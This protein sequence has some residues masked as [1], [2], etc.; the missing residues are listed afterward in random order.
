[1]H[2]KGEKEFASNYRPISL[3]S[4]V[5]KVMKSI[6]KDDIVAFTVNNKLLANLQH[7]FVSGKSCQTNVLLM[8]NF[9]TELIE[10]GTDADLVYL[11]CAKAFDSVPQNRLICKLYNYGISGNL[12]LW[13]RN[14]LSHRRQQAWVK[15]TLSNWENVTGCVPQGSVFGPVL[16][17]I[18]IIDLPIDILVLLFL[19]AD[20]TKLMQNLIST[21]SH[22]E[23]QDDINRLFEMG[24]KV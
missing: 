9:L 1:M 8:L 7:G 14:F 20:D 3:T 13:I 12:L 10:N 6:I 21:T 23:L 18:Y 19:F 17:I 11:D 5:F 22:N 16:F 4:F 24:V 2:E 15:S